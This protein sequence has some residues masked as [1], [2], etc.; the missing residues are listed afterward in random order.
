[1]P[2][3]GAVLAAIA[4]AALVAGCGGSN[5]DAGGAARTLRLH[6]HRAA[7]Q[8][9]YQSRH[10][11]RPGDAFIASS[12]LDGGGHTESY[13]VFTPRRR[14]TWCAVTVVLRGG[15]LTAEGAFTDAPRSSGSIAVLS[16][17]GAF[18]GVHG[19]LTTT[20]VSRPDATI[21]IRLQ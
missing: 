7:F 11:A 19:S 10:G 20:G 5:A 16:G 2:R 12:A 3:T 14:T 9:I 18:E 4:V 21:T 15:Q 13:C 6:A 17:A 8:P 1:M